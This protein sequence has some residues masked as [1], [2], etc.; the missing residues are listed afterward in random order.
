[1]EEVIDTSGKAPQ[2]EV[3]IPGNT[4]QDGKAHLPPIER[5]LSAIVV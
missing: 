2:E 3:A 4:V 1:M 5:P